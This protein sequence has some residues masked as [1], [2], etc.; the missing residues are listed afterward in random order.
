M[1]EM[2]VSNA[3]CSG[4]LSCQAACMLCRQPQSLVV[5]SEWDEYAASRSA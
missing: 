1:L 3:A 2:T 5:W 4:C